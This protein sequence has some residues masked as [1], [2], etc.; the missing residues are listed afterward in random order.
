VKSGRDLV[1]ADDATAFADAI[2]FLLR[3]NG[4]RRQYEE[5]ATK[6]AAQYDWSNI[7]Q[8]FAEILRNVV[9]GARQSGRS[10]DFSTSVKT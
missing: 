9:R 3:D 8:R 5:A 1:L 2:I 7:E 4:R 10:H 6:L